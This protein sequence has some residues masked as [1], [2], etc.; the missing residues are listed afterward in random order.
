MARS[1]AG[2]APDD[3]PARLEDPSTHPRSAPQCRRGAPLMSRRTR[4]DF[5]AGP[6]EP[7]SGAGV[8]GPREGIAGG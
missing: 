1:D 8:V 4:N 2:T 5:L 3:G 7:V 6:L